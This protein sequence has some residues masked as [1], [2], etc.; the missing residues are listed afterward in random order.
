MKIEEKEDPEFWI[1]TLGCWDAWVIL[2]RFLPRCSNGHFF[3]LDAARFDDAVRFDANWR[4]RLRGRMLAS[5]T[6]MLAPLIASMC[7]C[8]DD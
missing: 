5:S 6:T 8:S 7:S 2:G 3:L 1:W 4:F